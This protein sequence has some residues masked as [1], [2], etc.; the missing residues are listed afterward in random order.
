MGRAACCNTGMVICESQRY[1]PLLQYVTCS[2]MMVVVFVEGFDCLLI[3]AAM[4]G[5]R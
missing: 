3:S 4:L 1:A 2:S 5:D